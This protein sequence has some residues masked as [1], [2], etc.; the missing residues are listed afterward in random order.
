M[1]VTSKVPGK[2]ILFGEHAV[3]YGFPAI[4][5]AIP[6][7]ST[8]TVEENRNN[9]IELNFKTINNKFE[10]SNLVD[11]EQKIPSN[12]SQFILGLNS[13][14]KN[15]NLIVKDIKIE[16]FS[17]IIPNAGLGS[18]ASTSIALISAVSEF[19]NLTL[20][21]AEILN[22]ALEM[23]K[24]THGSPSGIDHTSCLYGNIIYY[25]KGRPFHFVYPPDDFY[26]LITYTNQE[27]NTKE[28]ISNVKK[29]KDEN[30]HLFDSIVD[31][32]GF[33]TEIAE[34]ELI[35]G[36]YEEAGKLMNFNQDLLS[37]LN[38]SNDTIDTINEI[39]LKNGA[40]GSKLTGAGL[41]GC[42]ITLG[43]EKVLKKISKIFNSQG[44]WNFLTTQD[45]NGAI[46][47]K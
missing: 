28:V 17:E 1:R 4:S 19:Y 6:L 16:L 36:N 31:K 35:S 29:L 33:Y 10:G 8:C 24:V 14:K 7:N 11:I 34:L 2:C 30:S 45:K 47:T 22:Y 3:V 27:H 37:Q 42:V 9:S 23:E 44:Y 46:T 20:K 38:V 15:F 18:S 25:Q 26:V 12:Y 5:M 32:I 40:Y 21:K 39:A 13:L 41:G 43:E